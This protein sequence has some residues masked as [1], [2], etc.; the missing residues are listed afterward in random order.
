MVN[1][2][3]ILNHVFRGLVITSRC[4]QVTMLGRAANTFS[5]IG[6]VDYKKM[7]AD[8][9]AEI[10]ERDVALQEKARVLMMTPGHGDDDDDDDD[11]A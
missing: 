5:S 10:G 11:D 4:C 1:H 8:L 7:E 9:R 3:T 6:L 2:H